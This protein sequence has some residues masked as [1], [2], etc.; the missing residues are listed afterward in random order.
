MTSKFELRSRDV[1]QL[2]AGF[3]THGMESRVRPVAAH[4]EYGMTGKN[5]QFGD[6]CLYWQKI[7]GSFSIEP[8]PEESHVHF[9]LMNSGNARYSLRDPA[10]TLAQGS[11]F[12]FRN[13]RGA[14]FLHGNEKAGFR[15]SDDILQRRM[16]VLL[17][18]SA[19]KV[20]EFQEVCVEQK[21]ILQFSNFIRQFPHSGLGE[22]SLLAGR[23]PVIQD[24]IVDS[25]LMCYPHSY[26]D[27][28]LHP[29]AAVSPKQVKRALAYIHAN[30]A[31]YVSQD[32][33]ANLSGV[34]LRSLQLSFKA[35]TGVTI[36]R[37]QLSLKLS[38][39]R[40]MIVNDRSLPLQ[41]IAELWGF[42][43]AAHF[44]R[45]F[46]QEFGISP[47]AVRKDH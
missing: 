47:S 11:A 12:A 21:K 26:S 3:G 44:S 10:V 32:Y 29:V 13:P 37:Y 9:V 39:A 23:A 43:S 25:F 22:M 40:D 31:E 15:V 30:P 35:A 46:K 2:E 42:C 16:Q 41:S 6:V 28:L 19:F 4:T 20:V 45:C 18:R 17:D 24:F 8:T 5:F 34:S 33:L 14:E 27:I 1:S 36:G 7:I 38:L